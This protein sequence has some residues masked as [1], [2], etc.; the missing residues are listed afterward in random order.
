MSEDPGDKEQWRVL[1]CDQ[2]REESDNLLLLQTQR[3]SV[4]ENDECFTAISKIVKFIKLNE[5]K[6]M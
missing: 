6:K 5:T 3:N 1:A 4:S 2:R